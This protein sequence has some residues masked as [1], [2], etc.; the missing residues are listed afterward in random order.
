MS[1][2]TTTQRTK[3][4]SVLSICKGEKTFSRDVTVFFLML[5]SN[6]HTIRDYGFNRNEDEST[7]RTPDV[8]FETCEAET[9][10]E[11]L[12]ILFAE[13]VT[14]C[15]AYTIFQNKGEI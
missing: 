3:V 5:Y 14:I 8:V 12:E 1:C 7:T 2:E 10:M 4:V 9:D 11:R 6:K 15:I 13:T